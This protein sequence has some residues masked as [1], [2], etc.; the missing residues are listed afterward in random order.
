MRR[1]VVF[2]HGIVI[3]RWF[4]E[5]LA[6]FLRRHGLEVSNPSYP[7][8]RKNIEE[9]AEEL[10]SELRGIAKEADAR[11]DPWELSVVAHSMGSLVFRYAMTHLETPAVRRAVLLGPPNAGSVTARRFR[12]FPPYRWVFGTKAGSQLAAELPGIY[13]ECGVPPA[14]EIGII[15]G[16]G[17]LKLYPVAIP[18]PHDGV[19]ALEEARLGDCPIATVPFNHTTMLFRRRT[20]ELVLRFLDEG[21]FD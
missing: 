21:K 11:G 7:T 13:E 17:N 10:A 20:H 2:R 6:R 4:M 15:A 9:H 12:N 8:T 19:V 14:T 18:K 16:I 1:I 5:P 3:N